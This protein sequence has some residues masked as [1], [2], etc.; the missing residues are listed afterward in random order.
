VSGLYS[1]IIDTTEDNGLT[2]ARALKDVAR[3]VPLIKIDRKPTEAKLTAAINWFHP[4]RDAFVELPADPAYVVSLVLNSA[5]M[6]NP[7][8]YRGRTSPK[9]IL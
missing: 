4:S 1:I 5:G 3:G 6:M 7:Q 9:P 8:E 2:N